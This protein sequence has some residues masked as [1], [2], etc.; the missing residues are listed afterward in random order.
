MQTGNRP[1]QVQTQFEH[2][3]M[4]GTETQMSGCSTRQHFDTGSSDG[5]QPPTLRALSKQLD[6]EEHCERFG[7]LHRG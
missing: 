6:K 1:G 3:M 4:Q 2:Q 5:E 7:W